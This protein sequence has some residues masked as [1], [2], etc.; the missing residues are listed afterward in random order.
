MD[1]DKIKDKLMEDFIK[2]C[3][4]LVYIG[5]KIEMQIEDKLYF[6][7]P[8]CYSSDMLQEIA[9]EFSESMCSSENNVL[10]ISKKIILDTVYLSVRIESHEEGI[11]ED[12]LS[13]ILKNNQ[14]QCYGKY[15]IGE[16]WTQKEANA[17][18]E[19]F[20][21]EIK[22]EFHKSDFIKV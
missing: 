9:N 13:V 22:K 1:S 19:K 3:T 18:Y 15:R 8:E 16:M 21:N 12:T 2:L 17:A 11:G 6:S 14:I 7:I 5:I 4:T 10:Q 20:L